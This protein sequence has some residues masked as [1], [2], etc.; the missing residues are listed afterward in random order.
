MIFGCAA[1]K[2]I[3]GI[4]KQVS[5]GADKMIFTKAMDTPRAADPAD[6]A[7]IYTK[8]SDGRVGQVTQN[9]EQALSIAD[10]AVTSEDLICICGSFYLVGEAKQLIR[11]NI[12]LLRQ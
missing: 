4:M 12:E 9:L 8:L 11:D 3:E 2:D 6:L 5:T 7:E 1:D 10:A